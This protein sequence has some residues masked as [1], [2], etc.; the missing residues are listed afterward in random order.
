M[1]IWILDIFGKAGWVQDGIKC[2][3]RVI[4]HEALNHVSLKM[5]VLFQ[6]QSLV[7]S[8][9]SQTEDVYVFAK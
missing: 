9:K 1:M 2:C 3:M 8:M 6:T 4:L 7:N 5:Y